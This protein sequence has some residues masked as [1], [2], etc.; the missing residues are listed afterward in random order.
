[1][2]SSNPLS[3]STQLAQERSPPR[4]AQPPTKISTC[5]SHTPRECVCYERWREWSKL[6]R[7]KLFATAEEAYFAYTCNHT[8]NSIIDTVADMLNQLQEN[9]GQLMSHEILKHEEIAKDTIY[10]TWEP[11]T[12][13]LSIVKEILDFDDITRTLY[14]HDQ[15]VN[16]AYVII[17]RTGKLGLAIRKWNRT[18]TVQRTWVRFKQFFRK[19]HW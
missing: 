17:H 5:G 1:M 3:L 14:T 18:K 19:A 8:T 15:D 12:T 6:L 11:I 4:M 9:H 2:R 10:N 16:I 7:K 13:V